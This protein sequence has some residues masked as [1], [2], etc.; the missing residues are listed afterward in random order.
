MPV[1]FTTYN[2]YDYEDRPADG[3]F[4]IKV[5][6]VARDGTQS[7]WSEEVTFTLSG[8]KLLYPVIN[9]VTDGVLNW[10]ANSDATDIGL[11]RQR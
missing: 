8:G 10:F 3:K 4:V 1:K 7:N 2:L 6:A 11:Y 5:R 9:G